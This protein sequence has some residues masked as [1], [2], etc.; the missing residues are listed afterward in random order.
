MLCSGHHG[1]AGHAIR[2]H[3]RAEQRHHRALARAEAPP[4]LFDEQ[5]AARVSAEQLRP[6]LAGVLAT[7][8]AGERDLLLLIAWAD[9]TYAPE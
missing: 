6:R 7:L 5:S 4:E 8:S 3:R 9:L 2:E 1:I